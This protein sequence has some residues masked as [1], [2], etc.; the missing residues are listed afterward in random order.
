MMLGDGVLFLD[1]TPLNLRGSLFDAKREKINVLRVLDSAS[2]AEPVG[3][4]TS[5]PLEMRMAC[6]A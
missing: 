1:S 3:F 4:P 6:F 2:V 5:K